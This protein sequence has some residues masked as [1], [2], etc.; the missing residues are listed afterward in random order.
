MRKKKINQLPENC[1]DKG[2]RAQISLKKVFI[3]DKYGL[4]ERKVWVN[5]N[6]KSNRKKEWILEEG[7]GT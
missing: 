6:R 5:R 4:N 7:S 1:Q 3:Y 2:Q